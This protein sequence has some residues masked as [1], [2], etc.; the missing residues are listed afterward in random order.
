[1]VTACPHCFN[2]L[3]NE[4]PAFGGE[5]EVVHHS[6]L[7]AQLLDE[8]R[9]D[10]GEGALKNVTFHDPCFLGR[11]NDET[12]APR[13]SLAAVKHLNV[14]EMKDHGRK[15]LCCGAG[16]AQMWKEEEHGTT[17]V[18]IL[19]TEQAVETKAEAVAVACPFCKTMID[20]GVKQAEKEEEIAVLD[21]AEVVAGAL[22]ESA[23]AKIADARQAGP[24]DNAEA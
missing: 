16:G 24:T 20:D 9:L 7:I 8:G 11:W 5:Y 4:Y 21:I 2:T 19:R 15:S 22:S 17:R 13:K 23:R 1:M 3:K 18:N 14:V 10:L 12:E 6:Q